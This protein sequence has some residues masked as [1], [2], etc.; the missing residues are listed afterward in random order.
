MSKPR[1]TTAEWEILN[2]LWELG[3]ATVREVHERLSAT[4]QTQYT[5]TLKLMQIMTAKGLVRRDE[6]SRAH[7]YTPSFRQDEMQTE[8]A[9]DLLD[10]VFG[11]SAASLMQ[12]AIGRRKLKS[13][14]LDEL[15]KL[16]DSLEG[17]G[18]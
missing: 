13:A 11:G 17:G 15:R 10:R 7:Q 14:E 8:A 16:I 3:P 5:T 1:P 9:R 6:T 2:A 4:G 18:K 12:R